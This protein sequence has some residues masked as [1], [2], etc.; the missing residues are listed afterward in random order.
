MTREQVLV[1]SYQDADKAKH[2]ANQADTIF[3]LASTTKFL[4]GVAVTQFAAQGK[5]DFH[6]TPGTYVDGFPA[7]IADAVTVHNLLTHTSGFPASLQGTRGNWRTRTEAF[8]GMLA[9]LRKQGLAT[10]PGT[11]SARPA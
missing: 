6:A 3:F 2:I 9:L 5:V 10:T 1:R 11:S 8:N 4:T 7:A